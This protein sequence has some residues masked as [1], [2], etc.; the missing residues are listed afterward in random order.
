MACAV[1]RT[2]RVLAAQAHAPHFHSSPQAFA[3]EQCGDAGFL[4]VIQDFCHC[5]RAFSKWH[6]NC[7]FGL[8]QQA[9]EI[10]HA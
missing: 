6:N 8:N 5:P 9:P 1:P 3:R 7:L 4:L 10:R 2:R